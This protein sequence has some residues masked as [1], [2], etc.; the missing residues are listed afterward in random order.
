MNISIEGIEVLFNNHFSFLFIYLFISLFIYL[1][2]YLLFIFIYFLWHFSG[3]HVR[4]CVQEATP[5]DSIMYNSLTDGKICSR[6]DQE[7]LQSLVTD[8]FSAFVVKIEHF[9]N[10]LTQHFPFHAIKV[11]IYFVRVIDTQ[12]FEKNLLVI[13]RL[14]FHRFPFLHLFIA[15]FLPRGDFGRILCIQVFN[16]RYGL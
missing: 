16:E 13:F 14:R 1:L 9:C 3:T 12:C 6:T 15:W 8:V 5:L 11:F 4:T 10:L 2:I 7:A